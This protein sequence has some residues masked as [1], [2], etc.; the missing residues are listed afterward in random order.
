MSIGKIKQHNTQKFLV[1]LRKVS[2]VMIYAEKSYTYLTVTKKELCEEAQN[3]TIRYY[4]TDE[5][6][7][8]GRLIMVVT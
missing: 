7:K 2:Q 4:L 6:F 3:T 8:V 1:D 5:I